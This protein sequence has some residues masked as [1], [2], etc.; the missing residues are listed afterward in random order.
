MTTVRTRV[1]E[2]RERREGI[3]RLVAEVRVQMARS[4]LARIHDRV[5]LVVVMERTLDVETRARQGGRCGQRD[6]ARRE[7]NES[8]Q[9]RERTSAQR[10]AGAP[11]HVARTLVPSAQM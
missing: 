3:G 4:R 9:R 1:P 5:V 7:R 2:G 6:D 8:Q 11:P 10:K